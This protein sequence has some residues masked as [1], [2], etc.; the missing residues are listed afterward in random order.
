MTWW[1]FLLP[2]LACAGLLVALI[3]RRQSLHGLGAALD[4]REE[5]RQSGS[6]R[7]RLQYPH[8]DL[9]RCL[10]CGTCVAACPEDGVLGLIHGQALVVH[11]AR[12]VGHG[13]C[14]EEC[15]TGA[16][17][18]ALGD[19]E[20]REDIPVLSDNLESTT[21][22]GLFLAGEVTG[23]ALIR[24]AVTHG[25]AVA[26][27][28]A[29]R[30]KDD[31]RDLPE[32]ALELCVV[33]AGPAGLSC[34][35]AAKLHGIDFVTLEQGSVGGTV[36]SYPR[37]KLVMTQPVDLPL[38]GRL[39]RSSYAKEELMELWTDIIGGLELP[40]RTPVKF[41]RVV[42]RADGLL[43]VQTDGEPVVA[44]F[45]SLALGR[46]GSPRRLG[47]PGEEATHVAYS[48]MDAES[49]TDRRILVVGGGDSAVEAALGLADQPGNVVRLSYRRAEFSRL[50]S[51]NRERLDQARLDGSVELLLETQVTAIGTDT[52]DLVRLGACDGEKL[53]LDVDEVFVF[54]GGEAPIEPL[55]ASGIS[56]DP[57]DRPVATADEGSSTGLIRSLG[58]VLV[59]A[60][61]FAGAT[62]GLRDYYD[63]PLAERPHHPWHATLRPAGAVGLTLGIAAFAAMAAN[64]GYLLRRSTLV[65]VRWGS[66]RAW[67]TVHVATGLSVPLLVLMH[68]ALAPRDTLGGHSFLALL[69]LAATG[70]IG[71]YFYSFVPRAANGR[72]LL[73]D[74]VRGELAQL[75]GELDRTHRGFGDSVLEAVERSIRESRGG[76]N[77]LTRLAA[78]LRSRRAVRQL[79]QDLTLKAR[80][81]GL[82]AEQIRRVTEL[83]ARAR[84]AAAS[85]ASFEDLRGLMVSWRFLHRW[86]ALFCVL[87]VIAHIV[88]ALRFT[89]FGG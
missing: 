32:G 27:E 24:T 13:R 84:R 88:V 2:A 49:Y 23:Y 76:R 64:L 86:A 25:N 73:L 65:P 75:S 47:V 56:F 34:S 55:K 72:E 78:V 74:E 11:G 33:G 12:C 44:R 83:A 58:A 10:G 71:R 46:R 38:H 37:R 22:P 54:A 6:H 40:I 8:V 66:L 68:A 26:E 80:D 18:I 29:R 63:L 14:A 85:A 4:E 69:A 53:M 31:P 50:R 43:E 1:T 59:L 79:E 7:A 9:D 57:A 41:K 16:I 70:A 77:F 62:F 36:A 42:Q 48:L 21:V 17:S 35:L 51:R 5:A 30:L 67:M 52:V 89:R 19:I 82:H 61:V 39:G 3:Q 15:P 28:I 45:V 60:L 81:A 87:A 20:Q